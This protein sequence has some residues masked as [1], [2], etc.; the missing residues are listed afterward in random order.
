MSS[1][2]LHAPKIMFPESHNKP[3]VSVAIDTII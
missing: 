3:D 2:S 1:M